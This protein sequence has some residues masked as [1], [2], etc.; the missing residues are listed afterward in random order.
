MK[1]SD[2]FEPLRKYLLETVCCSEIYGEVANC[3]IIGVCGPVNI[4][5]ETKTSLN[6]KVIDQAIRRKWMAQ[7]I[8]VAV[9][10][11][12]EVHWVARDLLKYHGI[13]LLLYEEENQYFKV[14]IRAKLNRHAKHPVEFRKEYL[15]D[16]HK[17]QISGVKSGE[18]KTEYSVMIENIIEV[19]D[20]AKR[21]SKR[22]VSDGWVSIEELLEKGET[23]YKNPK[24]SLMATLQ[25]SWNKSWCETKWING[26]FCVR[27]K[28][29]HEDDI[30][31]P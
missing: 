26:V 2:L 12:R 19:L 18:C 29:G 17:D 27:L 31:K 16:Y 9:P 22:K 5:V 8:Y 23:H 24:P 7:Y 14:D 15:K 20:T 1:E 6:F 30:L 3:D 28:A 11:P 10:K 13:G 25:K 21:F 4:A